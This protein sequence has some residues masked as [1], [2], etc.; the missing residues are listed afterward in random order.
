MPVL[1]DPRAHQFPPGRV[2]EWLGEEGID[3]YVR[4]PYA[5]EPPSGHL[6]THA[7]LVVL[8]GHG[9]QNTTTPALACRE[10]G[11]DPRRSESTVPVLGI[12]MGHQLAAVALGGGVQPNPGAQQ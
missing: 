4:P 9:C 12:C 10:H 8:G 11:A 1:V 6:A 2:G 3:L 7:G 5:G